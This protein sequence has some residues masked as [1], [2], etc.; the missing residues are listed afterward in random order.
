MTKIAPEL[1]VL[2]LDE[3]LYNTNRGFEGMAR[4]AIASSL[5]SVDA[6]AEARG[7]VEATGGSFDLLGHLADTGVPEDELDELVEVFGN[8]KDKEDYL[9]PDARPVIRALVE[10]ESPFLTLT[11]GGPKTQI[12]KLRSCGLINH[13]YR[14]TDNLYK[15][16]EIAGMHTPQGTYG[17]R[18]D[19]GRE[20]KG[21]WVE[22]ERAFL[23]EDKPKGFKGRPKDCFGMLIR[24]PGNELRESQKGEL[25]EGIP[26]VSSLDP[27]TKRIREVAEARRS[28]TE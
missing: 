11:K 3:A 24:R 28:R 7:A 8:N 16:V 21:V 20:G 2:D 1:Y 25:P 26:V 15:G 19:I 22:G 18:A 9:Y 4:I 6:L 27:L 23:L 13:P 5:S 10:T 17:A 12:A 14:I